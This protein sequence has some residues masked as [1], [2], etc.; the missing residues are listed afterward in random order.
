[1]EF[2][3]TYES[4]RTVFG[5]HYKAGRRQLTCPDNRLIVGTLEQMTALADALNAMGPSGHGA[6]Q[7]RRDYEVQRA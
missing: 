1:M 7:C 3:V 4:W 2:C 5:R 6:Y